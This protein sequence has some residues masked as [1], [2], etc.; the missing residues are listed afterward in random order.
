MPEPQIENRF[1]RAEYFND[2]R[3]CI[4]TDAAQ[5]AAVAIAS[6][7]CFWQQADFAQTLKTGFRLNG[8]TV[9]VCLKLKFYRG[10]KLVNRDAL[11]DGRG[12]SGRQQQADAIR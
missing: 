6:I 12:Y 1:V 5:P 8:D 4:D 9:P 7:C 2:E 10:A 11:H 3:F